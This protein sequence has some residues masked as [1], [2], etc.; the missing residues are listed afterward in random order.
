MGAA[1]MSAEG[2]CCCDVC[3]WQA[4]HPDVQQ[5]R[6]CRNVQVQLPEATYVGPWRRH[7]AI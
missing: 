3:A 5:S 4:L 2:K 1:C 7:D 6:L